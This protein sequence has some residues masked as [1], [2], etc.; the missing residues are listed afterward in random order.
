MSI[1]SL[2]F[3]RWHRL[4]ISIKGN[5]ATAIADC[6]RQQTRPLHRRSGDAVSSSGIVLLAQQIDDDTF[7]QGDLQHLSL[8]AGPGAAYELCGEDRVPGCDKPLPM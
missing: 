6:G 8:A 3:I 7:F 1:S 5:S 4:G 2:V